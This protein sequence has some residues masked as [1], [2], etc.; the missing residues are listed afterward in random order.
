MPPTGIPDLLSRDRQTRIMSDYK[1]IIES[2]DEKGRRRG[3]FV[4]T[5]TSRT[6][7]SSKIPS[8]GDTEMMNEA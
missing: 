6:G 5:H 8:R 7:I 3:R 2:P 1:F 4:S